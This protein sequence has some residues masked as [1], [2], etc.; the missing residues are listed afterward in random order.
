MWDIGGQDA[1]RSSWDTYY[2]NT[3][4]S[5]VLEISLK[6][7]VLYS[8]ESYSCLFLVCDNSGR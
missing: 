7:S 2:A 3:E 8:D 5:V 1:L 4:V 6:V